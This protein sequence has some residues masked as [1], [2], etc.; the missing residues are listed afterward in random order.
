[1]ADSTPLARARGSLDFDNHPLVAIW[2]TTQ[3]CDLA[4][5]HC[6][7]CATPQVDPRELS[8]AQGKKLLD[9]FAAMGTFAR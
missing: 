7:A 5:A 1:M 8:T 6:R 2:E 9:A 4:C 3:A